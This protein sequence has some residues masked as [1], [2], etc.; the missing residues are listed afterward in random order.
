MGSGNACSGDAAPGPAGPA[1]EA[2]ET[3]DTGGGGAGGD[4]RVGGGARCGMGG[5]EARGGGVDADANA[6]TSGRGGGTD[7][8]GVPVW[9]GSGG[10][11]DMPALVGRG[12]GVDAAR[13][14]GAGAGVGALARVGKGGGVDEAGRTGCGAGV[15]A[16]A[17][18]GKGAGVGFSAGD[19]APAA[20]SLAAPV[21]AVGFAA[22]GT[23]LGASAGRGLTDD[24]DAVVEGLSALP[25]VAAAIGL[26]ACEDR[27]R[28]SSTTGAQHFGHRT[29][30]LAPRPASSSIVKAVLHI[31]QLTSMTAQPFLRT[32]P[33]A[34]ARAPD[35]LVMSTLSLDL[36]TS[37]SSLP[38]RAAGGQCGEHARA[39]PA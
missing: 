23:D 31:R 6:L 8:E 21:G 10:G 12:G 26:G 4:G 7:A 28:S 24:L 1:P 18:V 16:L 11:V 5:L 27:A 3:D 2:A 20:G 36:P 22:G 17:R 19:R 32:A 30:V 29:S 14:A 33:P 13:R 25:I 15:G 9:V 34:A 38:L 35:G 39:I 37:G